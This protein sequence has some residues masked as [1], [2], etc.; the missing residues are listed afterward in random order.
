MII[1]WAAVDRCFSQVIRFDIASPGNVNCNFMRGYVMRI[2]ATGVAVR[3]RATRIFRTFALAALVISGALIALC[4]W[5]RS[6][7]ATMTFKCANTSSGATWNLK[8]DLDRNMV[9]SF[10]ALITKSN[11]SWRDT[12]NGGS[13]DLDRSSG[14]LTW[15]NSSSTGGYMLY[16]RCNMG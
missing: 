12:V 15:V 3:K 10:P 11:I 2:T 1:R 14:A 16:H 7:A 6:H 9:D 8:V 5:D 4:R 13:Y